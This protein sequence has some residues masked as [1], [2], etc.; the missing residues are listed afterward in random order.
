MFRPIRFAAALWLASCLC[1]QAADPMSFQEL[2]LR[3]RSGDSPQLLL[4]ETT[5][6]KLLEPLTP[7]QEKALQAAGA[8]PEWITAMEAP[9]LAAAP[10]AA[11]TF[12]A[13]KNQQQ[14]A[15]AIAAR[16]TPPPAPASTPVA[17]S[18]AHDTDIILV[19]DRAPAFNA[20]TS[21]G[22]MVTLSEPARKLTLLT[23]VTARSQACQEELKILQ[24]GL[25]TKLSAAGGCIV[26]LGS[27]QTADEMAALGREL[28]LTFTL[29][30]DPRKEIT[31]LFAKD[32]VPRCYVID[33]RGIVKYTSVGVN[34]QDL[35]RMLNIIQSDLR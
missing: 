5:Q 10:D 14:E 19:G 13:R 20:K 34:K 26:A 23:I 8:P 4:Q 16:A 28:G 11:A 30:E 32:F 12:R 6:R 1:S 15:A 7:G 29:A 27:G 9:E 21:K 2:S 22:D 17:V 33:Q 35:L 31:A 25:Q 3:L 24:Q 18:Q